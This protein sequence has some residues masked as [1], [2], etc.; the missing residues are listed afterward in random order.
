[1]GA[2]SPTSALLA[3]SDWATHMA[4]SPGKQSELAWH[5]FNNGSTL[6]RQVAES[7]SK[8]GTPAVHCVD[9]L[10][11]DRRFRGEPWQQWPWCVVQ[12]S[13]LMTERWWLEAARGVRGVD[14]HHENLIAFGIRQWLDMMSPGNWLATNPVLL[15][16]TAEQ[17][18]ANLMRGMVN[19]T[20]DLKT[21]ASGK[22]P[23]G[24][25]DYEV[26]RNLAL[27]PGKV[28]LRNGLME[29]I[30]YSPATAAVHPEP[31]LIVPAWIM[32][33]YILDLSPH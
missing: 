22:P 33:Y 13:F 11:N 4:V 10:P 16:R 14:Q 1:T 9:P 23:A 5:A 31:V 26:G 6:L 27:T 3:W 19:L 30:Q 15:Q 32:K 25:E 20:E 28:V 7:L 24:T 29:L 17:G 18:G 8:G 21:M 12:Q 2:L